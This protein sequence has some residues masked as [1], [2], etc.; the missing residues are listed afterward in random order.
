MSIVLVTG[1]SSGIGRA[2]AA[3]LA[4]DGYVVYAARREGEGCPETRRHDVPRHEK[5][6][7]GPRY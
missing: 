4:D 3:R 5:S 1:A 7:P 2:S 6:A